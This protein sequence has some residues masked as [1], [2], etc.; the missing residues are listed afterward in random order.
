MNVLINVHA[1]EIKYGKYILLALVCAENL[2]NVDVDSIS[3]QRLVDVNVTQHA[4]IAHYVQK[5]E[6]LTG[7]QEVEEMIVLMKYLIT[8]H[9]MIKRNLNYHKY[10]FF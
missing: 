6:I 7:L 1:Q 5:V 8:A 10:L 2:L 3:I 4:Q 9:E